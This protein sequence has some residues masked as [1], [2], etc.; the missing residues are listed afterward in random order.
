[1]E[2]TSKETT[3]DTETKP[4]RK[5]I[6]FNNCNFIVSVFIFWKFVFCRENLMLFLFWY[7]HFLFGRAQT[8]LK[9]IKNCEKKKGIN[10][11]ILGSLIIILTKL[12]KQY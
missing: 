7:D 12:A 2:N 10:N 9:H 4:T 5:T 6:A 11:I 1:M 8:F 3:K